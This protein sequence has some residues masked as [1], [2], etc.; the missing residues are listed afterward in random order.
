MAQRLGTGREVGPEFVFRHV[1]RMERH[2]FDKG[3]QKRG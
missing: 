1:A 3:T 2:R